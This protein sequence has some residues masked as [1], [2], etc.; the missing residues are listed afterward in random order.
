MLY[1]QNQSYELDEKL[2]KNPTSEYRAAPF[3]AWNCKLNKDILNEQID[4]FKKMGF[5]GFHMHSRIGMSTPY[6]KDEFMGL[7]KF[8]T[9]KAEQENMLAYLYDED[10]WPSGS[11]G[12]Y[13]TKT[14]KYRQRYLIFSQ[15]SREHFSLDEAINSSK[16][17]LLAVFDVV[18]NEKGELKSYHTISEND[19]AIGTKWYAYVH[20]HDES[21][22]HNNQTY[23]D[24]LNKEAI[25]EFIKITYEAYQSAV[26]DEFDKIIPSIFT[27][28]PQ[29]K[30][31]IPLS[32]ADSTDNAQL[33]W[34]FSLPKG[35]SDKYGYDI[36]GYLPELIWNLS[37][38]KISTARYHF[39]DYICD[40]FTEY[41]ADNCGDWCKNHNL[42]LAGHV[43]GEETLN[44]QTVS[45]GEAMRSYR[46]FGIPGID[47]LC[48]WLELTT[49]KQ[50]QS[51]VHQYGREAM[52]AELYG[53]T[54]WDFDFRGHK[55]QG[56]WLAALGVTVR[57]PHLSWVSMAGEAKRDYPASISYQSPW[58]TEYRY[59]EDHFAR[60][61]TALTRGKPVVKLA[62]IH[63]I[64]SYWI[65]FG[66]SENT[67][68][69]REQIDKKFSDITKWLLFGT[70]DFDFIS[71]ALLPAQIK[72]TDKTL[73]VG[74]M[75]YN[76]IIVPDCITLRRS[77]LEILEKF[78]SSGGKV[79]FAGNCP[80]YIDA[81]DCKDAEVLYSK[82]I[83]VPYDKIS[84]LNA[85][86]E[87]RT[88]SIK[89]SDGS[90]TNNLVY[91][92]REDN[93][94]KWLFIAH[95][96]LEEYKK[97]NYRENTSSQNIR[98]YIGGEYTPTLYNTLDG[99][100]CG[101]AHTHQNGQ[102]VIEYS[103][104]TNDSLLFR[105]D[106]NI[107]AVSLLK[108][109]DTCKPY[110]TIR[111]MDK[112]SYKRTEPNVLLI[113][114]A[115]YALNDEPFNQ[116]EEI[117]RLDN[118]CRR[119]CGF[120][121]KG[122]ALAQPWVVEDTPVK[123]YLTLKMTVNSEIEIL[124]AKL[125]IEDAETLQIQWNDETVSNIPDGWYVDKAIKTVPLPKINVGKN[126][127]IV[128]I[129]FGQRTNTE[130]CYIIGDFNVRNEGT[131]STIIPT[132][133]KISFSSLTNQGMPF[134]GGNVIYKTE[135]ET[136]DCSLKIHANYY[137]GALIKVRI[138]GEDRGIIAFSP[139]T[140]DIDNLSKGKHTVEFVLYG[141]RINTFGGM[142][143]VSQQEWVGPDFWRSTG[144][145]WCYEYI[146]K[147]TGILASP[148][149]EI[150]E[151]Q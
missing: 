7:I 66:P 70:V 61:N 104:Y 150:F 31:K 23:V 128:K 101:I 63:P 82:S 151:K 36:C 29:C 137:R 98:I 118:E 46:A 149:I 89:N 39:H 62:V 125:A 83:V 147:D 67:F 136:P 112:L 34:S 16:D 91:N 58:H 81:V 73:C 84:V 12:G 47:M 6:L 115:E 14:H 117:L 93:N 95:A 142:H 94:C 133:D 56:D 71:E 48:N 41:F 87:I 120:P 35:F 54:N 90:S 74:E 116:E 37:D 15:N 99:S 18:L 24:T 9:Q 110:K 79:I 108:T 17:Y 146:L 44:S 76:A 139:Y 97:H 8:C 114:R 107:R 30:P 124:G 109:D 38:N 13:V 141:T 100:V 55:F 77:T 106:S 111:F 40:T 11:A 10:R 119:K 19:T 1:K 27:D 122:D 130:W 52:L 42:L 53:V 123:N 49:A 68:D 59:I 140:I 33:P 113:D 103:L 22:W 135:I 32:F 4:I 121:L 57:V 143:N 102:T 26:G 86:S 60:L 105:L 64:E 45:L 80:K 75:E 129:P 51:A 85:V 43:M 21:P 50:C 144:D 2:F 20:T 131:I 25:D 96:S 69:I 145:N 148:V 92:M 132:T 138:D 126:T 134:Y 88:I 72:N 127:L 5:G 78:Q 3:W 28:E 65:N